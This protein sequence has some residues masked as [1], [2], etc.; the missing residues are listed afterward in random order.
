MAGL[1]PTEPKVKLEVFEE[2]PSDASASEVK[3]HIA[4]EA[5][6]REVSVREKQATSNH[7]VAAA[8]ATVSPLGG[9]EAKKEAS[10]SI[11]DVKLVHRSTGENFTTDSAPVSPN[12]QAKSETESTQ[13]PIK[14]QLGEF[15]EKKTVGG[16]PGDNPSVDMLGTLVDTFSQSYMQCIVHC[17]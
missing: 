8:A 4:H 14:A 3:G 16:E 11:T 6:D 15:E 9:G 1:P 10:V 13:L 2:N 17:L 7:G 12:K 5:G